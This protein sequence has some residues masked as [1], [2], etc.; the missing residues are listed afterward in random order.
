[1]PLLR[2]M[3]GMLSGLD[4]YAL[5]QSTLTQLPGSGAVTAVTP[6][7]AQAQDSI[8]TQ[9]SGHRIIANHLLQAADRSYR[10]EHRCRDMI[11]SEMASMY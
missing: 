4:L 10:R 6:K 3:T 1:M 8:R 5:T 9:L 11:R 2:G 7:A